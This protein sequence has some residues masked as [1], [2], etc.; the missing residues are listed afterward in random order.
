MGFTGVE[1]VACYYLLVKASGGLGDTLSTVCQDTGNQLKASRS[2]C[3]S[4]VPQSATTSKNGIS[5]VWETLLPRPI[6]FKKSLL[7]N[8][9]LFSCLSVSHVSDL[10]FYSSAFLPER[11][12]WY[13]SKRRGCHGPGIEWDKPEHLR[14]A[15]LSP[16]SFYHPCSTAYSC[17]VPL[18]SFSSENK[19]TISPL[20]ER[21]Q[22]Q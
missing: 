22:Q 6:G 7:I 2:G 5:C 17:I 9:S 12:L 1:A 21:Q 14:T 13:L 19:A 3:P 18:T 10:I 4:Q 11:Y 15:F 20:S 16:D 8:N